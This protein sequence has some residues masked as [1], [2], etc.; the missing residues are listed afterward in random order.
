M[1]LDIFYNNEEILF[2]SLFFSALVLTFIF[3]F[4]YPSNSVVKYK[5]K[6]IIDLIKKNQPKT[7]NVFNPIKNNILKKKISVNEKRL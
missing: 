5:T 6:N 7:K 3:I 2:I 4:S 1:A